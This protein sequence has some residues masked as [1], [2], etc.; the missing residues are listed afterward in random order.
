MLKI[1]YGDPPSLLVVFALLGDSTD[2]CTR[3][4]LSSWKAF[5]QST[6][7]S[8]AFHKTMKKMRQQSVDQ[9]MNQFK[10][11]SHLVRCCNSLLFHGGSMY[12]TAL[13]F[14]RLVSIRRWETMKPRILLDNTPKAHLAGFSFIWNFFNSSKVA[15]ISAK[16][17]SVVRLF[18]NMSSTYISMFLPIYAL[19]IEFTN[20]WYVAPTFFRTKS[21]T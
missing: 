20:L 11:A 6:L 17:C 1:S 7:H 21:M 19:N 14:S 13:I 15:Y 18:I 4:S 10:V 16:F 8:K 9:K 2:K 5:S 12:R 3:Q